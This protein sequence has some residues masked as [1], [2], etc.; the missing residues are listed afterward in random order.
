M[1]HGRGVH[2]E[3]ASVHATAYYAKRSV[4]SA[5]L[6]A[7]ESFHLPAGAARKPRA[8]AVRGVRTRGGEAGTIAVLPKVIG[9]VCEVQAAFHTAI[10][11]EDQET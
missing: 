9:G 7:V 3:F 10:F 1:D 4:F 11:T 8:E 6:A 2:L 5:A